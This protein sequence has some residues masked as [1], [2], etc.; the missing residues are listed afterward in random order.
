MQL[1]WQPNAA[2]GQVRNNGW[3]DPFAYRYWGYPKAA[4]NSYESPT[5]IDLIPHARDRNNLVIQ[6]VLGPRYLCFLSEP[7]ESK[8]CGVAVRKVDQSTATTPYIFIAYTAEQFEQEDL[9]DL[10]YISER[11][12]RE[13]GVPAYWVGCSCMQDEDQVEDD[14][15]RISD[16]MRGAQS[17]IIA[18]GPSR[19]HPGWETPAAMLKIWGERMWTLPEALL[20]PAD[21]DIKVYV[22]GNTGPP[23]VI[24]KKQFAAVVWDDPLISRQLVDHFNNTLNLSPLELVSIA[25]SC[26]RSRNT[27][28]HLP[29]D[30]S[31][32]LMG[33]LR[34]RPQIDKTDSDFQAFARLSLANDSDMLLERLI[35]ML[36]L[37]QNASWLAMDDAWNAN[38]WD[39]YPQCQ[40]A[41]LGH[42][43]TV[44]L[45]GAFG[46]AIRWKAFTTVKCIG[47]DSWKRLGSRMVIH[48]APLGFLIGITLIATSSATLGIGAFLLVI[49]LIVVLA[50]PYLVR[51]IYSGKLWATQAWFFGFE[52]YLDLATI[53]SQIFGA[54]MG[55]LKW[56][57]S[58]SSISKHTMNEHGECVGVDPTLDSRVKAMVEQARNSD[59]GAMKVFTLVDTYTLTVTMFLAVRPPVAVLMCGHEGGMQR[60]I[61][62]SYD[63]SSQ[64]LYRETVLRMETPVLERMFRVNRFRF[65]LQRPLSR[66]Q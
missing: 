36:P 58:G 10:H 28:Q 3:Y 32:A 9:E 42:H 38:L 20:S 41:G 21:K 1:L 60:A 40:V 16:V 43:D 37:D 66:V 31:Y 39:I 63:W 65:G 4:R 12:A 34:Q 29:G 56:S 52:G 44:I 5:S 64:T 49:S 50:S 14:V 55:R 2:E 26:L 19:K 53:E 54:Y 18:I 46:A 27:I 22:R 61:M 35:C 15:Y 59:Y 6:R 57:P 51:V 23:R 7:S 13:A 11:A 48:G 25:L 33:L 45:D 47:M 24:S 17:L 30:L 62:C 8:M